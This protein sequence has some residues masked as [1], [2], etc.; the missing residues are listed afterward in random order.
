MA[1]IKQKLAIRNMVENG[2]KVSTA[3]RKAGY[4]PATAK[5][6]QKLTE[7]KA[8]I[9]LVEKKIPDGKLVDKINEGLEATRTISA[10]VIVKSTDPAVKNE[11]A[12]GRSVDFIDVPDYATQHKFLETALKIKGKMANKETG[13]QLDDGE[14]KITVII[15]DY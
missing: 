12:N 14:K 11:K 6:P 5:T 4:S 1:T 15:R 9:E 10:N 3:M 2:G 8:W 13:L 7:S